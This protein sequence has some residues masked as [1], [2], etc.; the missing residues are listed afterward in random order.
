MIALID[1]GMGNLRSVEKA[2]IKLGADVEI[3]F[4]AERL[5]LADKAILPGVGAFKDTIAGIEERGLKS[6]I[7]EFIRSGK[8]Y[9]GICVGMQ[10]I[11]EES[12]EGGTSEGLGVIGGSVKRFQPRD[13]FKVPHMGWNEVKFA[14]GKEACPLFKGLEDGAYFYFDH[15]YYAAPTDGA[16]SAG[17]TDYGVDFTSA[18]W[19][20]NIFAV[21]FHPEKSQANGLAMIRNFIEL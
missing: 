14:K 17:I 20:D 21:Q 15:S 13:G 8:P 1:Y 6:A 16:V 2:L 4:D 11:F 5:S 7:L 19:K 9:F 12:S 18:V 3:V 10:V